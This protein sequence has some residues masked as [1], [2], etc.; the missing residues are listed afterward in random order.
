MLC[1]FSW[2]FVSIIGILSDWQHISFEY[3]MELWKRKYDIGEVL[4]SWLHGE[5][6]TNPFTSLTNSSL[7]FKRFKM[8]RVSR[9]HAAALLPGFKAI[10]LVTDESSNHFLGFLSLFTCLHISLGVTMFIYEDQR[11]RKADRIVCQKMER[12]VNLFEAGW[13]C[14][15]G[16]LRDLP[17]CHYLGLYLYCLTWD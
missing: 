9:P 10:S 6:Q 17:V 14:T 2:L 11:Q 12:N 5:R 16:D 15:R 13:W 7:W 4:G 1:I 8:G 3:V